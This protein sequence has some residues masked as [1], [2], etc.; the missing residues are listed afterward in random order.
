MFYKHYETEVCEPMTREQAF[1]Y[2]IERVP[3]KTKG[4]VDSFIDMVEENPGIQFRVTP[5]VFIS[6]EN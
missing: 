5:F 4:E 2:V 3:F 6:Y 1:A